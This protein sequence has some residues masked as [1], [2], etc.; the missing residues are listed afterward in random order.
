MRRPVVQRA[1]QHAQGDDDRGDEPAPGEAEGAHDD[2]T[3]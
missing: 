3:S 1:E 2:T